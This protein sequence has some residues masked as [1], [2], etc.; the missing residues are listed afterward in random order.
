MANINDFRNYTNSPA[1]RHTFYCYCT[2]ELVQDQ[3]VFF[4]LVEA[5]HQ[6][7]LKRQAVFLNDWFILGNIPDDLQ[8]RGYLGI[9][10]IADASKNAVSR[11]ATAAV[12]AIGK[13]FGDKMRNKGGGIKGFFG[14]MKQKIGDTRVD[15]A[16]FDQPQAQ[17]V[18]MLD[19]T[20]KHGFGRD[21]GAGAT[22]LPDGVYQPRGT[23]SH[24][25]PLFR[26]HLKTA[27]FDPDSLGIY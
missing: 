20:G 9:V 15:G 19:E 10:N 12:D 5:F 22:Y 16:L 3:A 18:G 26:K 24:Q 8:D 11:N 7:R 21:G 2:Q 25:V 4:L 17:V 1:R 27:G 13:T 6:S 23:F 14:A